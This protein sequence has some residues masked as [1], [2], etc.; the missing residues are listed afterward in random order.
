MFGFFFMKFRKLK[1]L[2]GKEEVDLHKT[3]AAS[4]FESF[5]VLQ[6][7]NYFQIL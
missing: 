1:I 3:L 2:R 6:G 4:L 7:I 5:P